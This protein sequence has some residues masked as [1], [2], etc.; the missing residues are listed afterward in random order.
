MLSVPDLSGSFA[1]LAASGRDRL[2][3]RPVD[4]IVAWTVAEVGGALIRL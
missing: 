4:T 1:V 3:A 2:Y